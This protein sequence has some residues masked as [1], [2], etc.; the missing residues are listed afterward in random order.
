MSQYKY[1]V[2]EEQFHKERRRRLKWE[3]QL[4]KLKEEGQQSTTLDRK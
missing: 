3:E 4:E 1:E 2:N